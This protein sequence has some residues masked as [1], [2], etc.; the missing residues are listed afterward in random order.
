MGG[1]EHIYKAFK[2]K[3]KAVGQ[4]QPLKPYW[5]KEKEMNTCGPLTFPTAKSH[6]PRL[7]SARRIS[8]DLP[9]F[10]GLQTSVLVGLRGQC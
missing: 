3:S 2:R 5:Q 10:G 7:C 4:K 1:P 9:K 8:F 6:L